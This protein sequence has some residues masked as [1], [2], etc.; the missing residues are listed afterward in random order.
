MTST[1]RLLLVTGAAGRIGSYYRRWLHET[2]QVGNRPGQWRL[3]LT[4]VRPL[5]DAVDGDEVIAG[6]GA[7]LADVEVAR[8]VVS[9]ASAVIHLAADP[10][11]RADFYGSLLDHN[12]KA[13]FNVL[14]ACVETGARRAILCSSINAV[15]GYPMQRQVRASDLAFPTNVY[16]ATKA[17]SE[18]LAGAFVSL[19]PGFSAI[20]VRI[21]GVRHPDQLRSRPKEVQAGTTILP[22]LNL[23]DTRAV[24]VTLPDLSRLF[25]RCL[26]AGPEVTFAVVNGISK[27]RHLRM[28]LEETRRLVGYEP[29]DDAFDDWSIEANDA[30]ADPRGPR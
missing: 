8:R 9:G 25:D 6:E 27:N 10:S 2:D 11:P 5:E 22:G 20:A 15:N 13:P 17:W 16:G 4:D 29:K 7:D 3:R 30:D 14:L 19:H 23:V 1:S 26:D 21:G 18:A 12:V 24:T 28:D